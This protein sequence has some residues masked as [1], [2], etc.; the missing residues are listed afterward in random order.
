[1]ESTWKLHHVGIPVRDLDA[2][3][4]DYQ[5]SG[6][7]SFGQEFFIDSSKAAEYLVYDKTPDPIVK[8]RGV[9]GKLGPLGIELLQP[10]EGHTVHKELLDSTGEGIG[11]IAYTVDDL[12]VETAR[13]IEKGFPVILSIKPVGR[14]KPSAAYFDT[15]AKFSNLIIELIQAN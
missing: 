12:E 7:A 13:L 4:D 11:H 8:T 14:A 1:M 6:F 15:R 2:S 9:M 10:V 5:S 3:M